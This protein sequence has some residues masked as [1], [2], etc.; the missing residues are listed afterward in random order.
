MQEYG[1]KLGSETAKVSFVTMTLE[2]S[3]VEWMVSFHNNAS[4]L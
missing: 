3:A 1:G 2:E 4:Q